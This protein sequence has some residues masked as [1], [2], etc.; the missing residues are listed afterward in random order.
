MISPPA[1]LLYLAKE[2]GLSITQALDR[3]P[4]DVRE[5]VRSAQGSNSQQRTRLSLGS[6]LSRSKN[7]K[8]S[9][10][11]AEMIN[12]FLKDETLR[13]RCKKL[14]QGNNHFDQVIREATTVFE[15]RLKKKTGIENSIRPLDLVGK[16][17][18]PNPHNAVIEV[19]KKK[20]EQ[21]GFHSLC[22]GL[23]LF[24]RNRT[25]HTLSD[26]FTREEA[27][28]FCGFIDLLLRFIEQAKVHSDRVKINT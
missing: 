27:L 28:E 8:S 19:S 6:K 11:T 13:K 15:D 16:A 1:A 20:D 4:P 10:I 25:H 17:V 23:I 24:F 7:R 5:E 26:E 2:E 18:N 21:E 3:Q 12:L 14:L 22:K 9:K